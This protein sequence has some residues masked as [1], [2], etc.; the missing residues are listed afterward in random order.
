MMPSTRTAFLLALWLLLGLGG[1]A[2]AEPLQVVGVLGNTSGLSDMPVP[3]AFYTGIAVDARGRLYLAGPRATITVC[4]QDGRCLTLL[5]LPHGAPSMMVRAGDAVFFVGSSP[6]G[7]RGTLYRIATAGATVSDLEVERLTAGPGAWAISPTLDD[8]GKVIVGQSDTDHLKYT[9]VAVDPASGQAT[10]LFTLDQPKGAMRPWR[11]VIQAEPGGTI[12]I[13]HAGGVDWKGRF[14]AKGARV[15]EWIDGQILDGLRYHFGYGGEIRRTDLTGTKPSPG[16]CGSPAPEIRMPAQVVRD[17]DR[18]FFAG[19]GGA[20]EARW[21]GSNFEFTRRIGGLCLEDM[22]SLDADLAGVAFTTSG[23]DDVQHFI[24]IPKAQPVGQKLD[25]NDPIYGRTVQTLVPAPNGLVAVYR[26]AK[27]VGVQFKGPEHLRYDVHLAEV[28]EIGQAAAL[29]KDLLLAD[30]KSGLVWRRPLADKQAPAVAWALKLPGVVGLATGPGAVYAA[31]AT[32][33]LRT[34]A[35]GTKVEWTSPVEYKGVRRLAATPDYVYVCDTAGHVVDQLDAKTGRQL[36]RLGTMGQSGTALDHLNRPNAVAADLNGVYV[37]DGGNGRV[38]VAT[39]TLWRPD[40]RTL[41]R[42]DARPIVAVAVPVKPPAA[43]RMSLN[44][45]DEN[46]ETVRQLVCAQPSDAAVIWDGRDQYG[47]YAKAG[48]YRW[49]ALLAPKLSLKYVMS[50][51]QSGTPPYRTADGKGSWGGVWGNVMDVCAVTSAPDSDIVVLWAVEEGEGGL[52]RMS[53]DG[54]V[55]WKQHLDWWM[56]AHQM[57]VASDGTSIYIA[58]S[59][60]M[61]APE[62][63]A[64]YG[65]EWNR[66]M[67]WRVD[68]AT[69]AKR[70]YEKDQAKQPMFGE[71]KKEGRIVTDIAVRGGKL[72][73]TAPAQNTLFVADAATGKELQAWK[74]DGVSGVGFLGP[75]TLIAGSGTKIVE[76]DVAGRPGRVLVDAGGQVWDV[77]GFADGGFVATVGEPRNQ[78]VFFD[79][80][81]KEVRALGKPGGRPRCGKMLPDSFRNPVGLGVTG[82]GKLFVAENAAPRRFTRWSAGGKLEREF[83]GPYYFSGMFGVDEEQPE[84]VYADTHT[85]LIRYKVDYATGRWEVDHYWIGAYEQSGVPIKWWPRIRHKDGRILWTSGSGAIAE[86]M[87]DRVRGLAA[88]YG[89]W[90]KKNADGSIEPEPRKNTGLKGTW[91]DLNGDGLKQ[92]EEWQ[93]TD[94][95]AYPMAGSGPQQG[96]GAYFDENFNLF[97]HDWSDDA[98]GGVWEIPVAEWKQGAPVYK[99]DQARHAGLSRDHGLQHGAAGARTAFAWKDAVY[100]LNA[101]Y[102]DA[103]LPGVGHGH[104]WEFAQVTKYDAATGRPLWHAGERTASFATPGQAYCPT[105]PAGVIGDLLFWTDENSLVHAWDIQHGLYVDTLLEDVSRGPDPSAYTVWVELFNTRVFRHPKTGKI[106]LMAGSDAIHVYEVLGT[107]AKLMRFDGT[108]QLSEAD[109]EKAKREE[110]GRV[111]P[112]ERTLAI[113]RAPGPVRIDGD[114]G[115]FAHEAAA[116]LVLSPTMQADARLLYDDKGLYLGVDVQDDSPWKNAGGDVTALFKTGDAVSLWLGPSAGKR[117]PG[118]GDVRL[119]FAPSGGKAT[120]VAYRPKVAEGAKPVTFRSPSGA[121]T[122]DKVEELADVETAVKVT[123]KGYRLEAAIPWSRI[124]L[125]PQAERFGLD[126]SVDFSDPAGQ[127]NVASLRWGRNGAAIVYDLPTEARFEPETWGVGVMGK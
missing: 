11:H 83:H 9:V 109:L 14:D 116:R 78:V 55:R 76:W 106:Y 42:E 126:V 107:D 24:T 32:Q 39:T 121:M 61:N 91:S 70:L 119:L 7:A 23:N 93:V 22:V 99:W 49:H 44:I 13:H 41:P 114:L 58:A 86:L 15:G 95:P 6:G 17:K 88:V 113:R 69:G 104:D 96:W 71:Y 33:V 122:L 74:I 80:K 36:A 77:E 3:Y 68:A 34:S 120:V 124:G 38:L 110:A 50:I 115:E 101:G 82:N 102:N 25:V 103:H 63:Q 105:G 46:D 5:A 59:S 20:L 94:K 65:G 31:S 72:Y 108:F 37:A 79:A 117:Q 73:L 100:A 45:Y 1:P 53:Q 35:D 60:A 97:M 51:G 26:D 125:S 89:G 62:G 18:F 87:D 12:G 27:G 64:Q 52:V 84:Y 111:V 98:V 123:D 85:D 16:D 48:T 29:D 28:Q 67:L 30:P 4:D 118:P 75:D 56:K 127:R 8:A 47:A 90:V 40:I 92:A 19:R 66:P 81:G 2:I 43:G 57:A 54:E 112:K 10:T 21:N